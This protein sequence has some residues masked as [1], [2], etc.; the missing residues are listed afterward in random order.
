MGIVRTM[1]FYMGKSPA[2]KNA[3]PAIDLNLADGGFLGQSFRR[4]LLGSQEAFK[5]G[6]AIPELPP[7]DVEWTGIGQTAGVAVWRRD[8][9]IGAAS[10]LIN[11]VE[12]D[13]E[14][15]SVETYF[16]AHN[17]PLPSG[18]WEASARHPRPL[19]ITLHYDLRSFT[20]P[21]IVTA[22]TAL[23]NAFFSMFG[24]SE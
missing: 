16:R 2:A 22:A 6:M 9:K 13:R 4:S 24:M 3:K 21:V 18:L 12:V 20:D 19:V 14:I 8:G 7:V 10:I 11:G 15:E 17:L 1:V 23:A 5:S